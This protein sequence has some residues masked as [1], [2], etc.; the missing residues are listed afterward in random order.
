MRLGSNI[1]VMTPNIETDVR[2]D[3]DRLD[4]EWRR[5][6]ELFLRYSELAAEARISCDRAK[7]ALDVTIAETD[8]RVRSAATERKP[9]ETQIANTVLLDP[10]VR[11][12]HDAFLAAKNRQDLLQSAVRA[13]EQRKDALE[14]LVRL[15]L[16]G[17]F[18]TPRVQGPEH[19]AALTTGAEQT[20]RDVASDTLQRRRRV[21]PT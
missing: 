19:S 18:A 7:T 15:G 14:N 20:R 13:M 17:Y 10:Q 3:Q 4:V 16:A 12:A 5:Q 9:T 21:D 6:P 11:G 1:A 2:I 8:A